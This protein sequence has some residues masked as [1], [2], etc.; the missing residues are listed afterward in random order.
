M[1]ESHRWATVW[2]VRR[3]SR[4]RWL[5]AAF[6]L[7]VARRC[8][9]CAP[10]HQE[11]AARNRVDHN[12]FVIG[13]PLEMAVET[14][15]GMHLMTAKQTSATGRLILT[16]YKVQLARISH[17]REPASQSASLCVTAR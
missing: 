4:K 17:T 10:D 5:L 15:A 16:H 11:A 8:I 14:K 7:I 9:G 13:K 12:Q 1:R 6:S 3:R 2:L